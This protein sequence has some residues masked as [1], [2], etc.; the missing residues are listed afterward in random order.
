MSNGTLQRLSQRR[1]ALDY[2]VNM[3]GFVVPPKFGARTKAPNL[4]TGG[5][6]RMIMS[7]RF[8]LLLILGA[9]VLGRK[10]RDS[11]TTSTSLSCNIAATGTTRTT[12]TASG[13]LAHRKYYYTASN[14]S[15]HNVRLG[16]SNRIIPFSTALQ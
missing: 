3:F 9:A 12:V 2:R 10:V 1:W 7:C 13:D 16:A 5:R 8:A 6:L 11:E 15:T 4:T 14:R